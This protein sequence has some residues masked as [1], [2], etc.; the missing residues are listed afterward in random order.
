[1]ILARMI[2]KG[3]SLMHNVTIGCEFAHREL[4]IDGDKVKVSLWDT[5]GQERYNAIT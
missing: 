3:F 5:S 2:N 4:E 1:M